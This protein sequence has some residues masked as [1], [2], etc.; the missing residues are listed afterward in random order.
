MYFERIT[1]AHHPMYPAAMELYQMSFPPHEQREAPS[2]ETILCHPDY[3]F[4]L[5]LEDAQ[6][7]GLVLYWE[8]PE[9][10]YV[11]HFCILPELRNRHYG[12]RTLETLGALGKAIILEIDPPTDS[13]CLRRKGFYERCG[14]T[15]NPY[16][17][18]HP[19]YH[20]GNHGHELVVMS[21]PEG[22]APEAYAAF[23]EYLECVVMRNVF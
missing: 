13:T 18:V 19:P 15:A 23:R 5:V 12:Q 9:F 3:H 22:I 7:V 20:S 16:A 1:D 17:H 14:F 21:C 8:T 11:E 10:L 2:Q 4:T 6:F